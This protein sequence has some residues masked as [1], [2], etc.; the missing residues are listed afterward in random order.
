MFGMMGLLVAFTFTGAASRFE[1]RRELV[2]QEANAIGHG[3]AAP[4]PAAGEPCASKP[5]ICFAATSATSGWP[6]TR[7]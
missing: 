6:F 4:G 2:V 7:T 5:A 1:Q 3:V